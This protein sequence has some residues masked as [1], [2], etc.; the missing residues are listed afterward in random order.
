MVLAATA[1]A[2][3][4][5]DAFFSERRQHMVD[6]QVRGR[7]I[8]QSGLLQAMETV[9]RHLFVPEVR[10]P[11][12]Y[13]DDPVEIAP[14]KT[15]SQAYVSALMISLLELKGNEKVLEV[16]TGS[17]Y[18]AALL[19][20]M[21]TRGEIYTIEIDESLGQRASA[22]LRNLGYDN[23]RVKIGDGY[24]G[25]PEEA[26]FDAILVTTAPPYPPEPLIEQLRVG[27]KM[28]IPVG[29]LLQ[30]LL[31]ITKTADGTERRKVDLV[32]FGR[33]TGEVEHRDEER[34]R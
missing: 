25:W 3:A 33:M 10:R 31:V 34:E 21:V 4:Q 13:G 15:L 23:V 9:P 11:D 12:A 29:S 19:S 30:N 18:D 24:R 27:G 5:S 2:P 22:T 7:G 20:R 14:G 32:N 1:A 8:D 28:V 16:G 17:G 26:P 6:D